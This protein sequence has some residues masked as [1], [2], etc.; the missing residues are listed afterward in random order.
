MP[1]LDPIRLRLRN[2]SYLSKPI[3]TNYKVDYSSLAQFP[4]SKTKQ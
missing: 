1:L 3:V 4:P 2:D